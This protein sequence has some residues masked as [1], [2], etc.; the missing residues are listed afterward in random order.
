[1]A[2]RAAHLEILVTADTDRAQRGLA[3]VERTTGRFSRVGALAKTAMMG[4]GVA[5][6][7]GGFAA[8]KMIGAASDLSETINKVDVVFGK[9]GDAIEHWGERAINTMGMSEQSAL[10]AAAIFGVFGQSAGL[11]GDKLSGF[12]TKLVK[13]AADLSSFH[14]VP[15]AESLEAIRSGLAGETEPLRRFGILLNDADL[16]QRALKLGIV[17][18]VKNALTPQQRTLAAQ[19]LILQRLG[20]ATGDYARTQSGLANTTRRLRERLA[21]LTAHMGKVLLPVAAKAADALDRV[22]TVVEKIVDA[23]NAKVRVDILI[24]NAKRLAGA[25][26]DELRAAFTSSTKRITIPH[27]GVVF[28]NKRGL[29][30]VIGAQIAEA[31]RSVDWSFVGGRIADGIGK[32]VK[33]TEDS[34]AQLGSTFLKA[35]DDHRGEIIAGALTLV[36]HFFET[37]TDPMFWLEH[38]RLVVEILIV[39]FLSR[40]KIVGKVIEKLPFGRF[41]RVALG[42]MA[43]TAQS[44]LGRIMRLIW[45]LIQRIAPG[46]ASRARGLV[47]GFVS[48]FKLLPT[49][50]GVLLLELGEKIATILGK[51]PG[52]MGRLASRGARA[53][54][55][56][57]VRGLS[58]LGSALGGIIKGAL[59]VLIRSLNTGLHW[60]SS[61]WPDVPGAP[62]P[63][64]FLSSGIPELARGTRRF[65]GGLALVGEKGPELVHLPRGT[66]VDNAR[67][68]RRQLGGSVTIENLTVQV[69]G[70]VAQHPGLLLDRIGH[71]IHRR[72]IPALLGMAG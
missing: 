10:D 62:G 56:G 32:G 57:L 43:D 12:S 45:R 23:P 58:G 42:K 31:V 59:N 26:W 61:K 22:L 6:A 41:L 48:E 8:Y 47:T 53:L 70:A 34:L 28:E 4:F 40:F 15:I 46:V 7:A 11:T 55:N 39:A 27:R 71:E 52:T 30:L 25:L 51:L 67:D 64:S 44:M 60:I 24:S 9:N 38:W 65:G 63:P 37:L 20:P 36:L 35:L 16:R 2:T 17:D 19:S 18:T 1:M 66:R 3:G 14:N 69:S 21:N 33:F 13:A 49:R 72:G 54:F 68:T 29:G 50:V 5:L